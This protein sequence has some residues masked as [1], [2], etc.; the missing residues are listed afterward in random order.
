[1]GGYRLGLSFGWILSF[2][3]KGSFRRIC[4]HAWSQG[5]RRSHSWERPDSTPS[6]HLQP[7]FGARPFHV[8][9]K[10]I[11]RLQSEKS[12]DQDPIPW[13]RPN[14]NHAQLKRLLKPS[15]QWLNQELRA[16]ATVHWVAERVKM[17]L[18]SENVGYTPNPPVNHHF[19]YEYVYTVY[20]FTHTYMYMYIYIYVC[21]YTYCHLGIIPHIQT[22][23]IWPSHQYWC[24]V[25]LGSI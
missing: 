3:L 13:P 21:I 2:H 12:L 24:S 20:T 23:P 16:A 8:S 7:F 18:P 5:T 22:H 17:A 25:S 14:P 9:T 4:C 19:P 11:S 6:S 15:K 10:A 1:M